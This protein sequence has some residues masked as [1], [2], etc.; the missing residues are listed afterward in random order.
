MTQVKI[1]RKKESL[2]EFEVIGEDHTFLSMLR[3]TLKDQPGVL[4]A[5]Y[6]FPH[7]LLENPI[8]YLQTSSTDPVKALQQAADDIIHKC[9]DLTNIFEQTLSDSV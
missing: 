5:A 8:F 9:D 7:P 4:F 6:R 1:I 3:E 2:L